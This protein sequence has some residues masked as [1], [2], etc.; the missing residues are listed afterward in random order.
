MYVSTA[1]SFCTRLEIEEK[2]YPLDFN[3][4]ELIK[5][6]DANNESELQKEELK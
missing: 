5:L 6:T 2:V 4:N 1:Y 3:Y